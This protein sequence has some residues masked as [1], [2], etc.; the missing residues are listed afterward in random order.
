MTIQGSTSN[1]QA[2]NIPDLIAALR[3][4]VDAR[5]L[6]LRKAA[7]HGKICGGCGRKL[8]A[9][10]PVWRYQQ[11]TGRG[12]FGGTC[13]DLAPYCAECRRDYWDVF[14]SGECGTCGRPVHNTDRRRRRWIFCCGQCRGRHLEAH[15]A[16]TARQRRAEARGASRPCVECGEH[17]EPRRADSKYCSPACKQKAYRKRVTDNESAHA[18]AFDSRNASMAEAAS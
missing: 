7:T 8:R 14:Q 16:A 10:E 13:S 9:D 2:D 12:L 3:A 18:Y 11:Q 15:Q 1:K 4:S 5:T 17:F 6:R